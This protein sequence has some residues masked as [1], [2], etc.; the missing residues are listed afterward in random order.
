MPRPTAIDV[1]AEL[2][3]RY[4]RGMVR[5]SRGGIDEFS[6]AQVRAAVDL[7]LLRRV[8][9]G[10]LTFPGSDPFATVPTW[11]SDQEEDEAAALALAQAARAILPSLPPE[12]RWTPCGVTARR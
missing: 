9:P 7:G 11:S 1:A 10:V 3:A 6:Y 5:V 12:A 4:G 8:R 2:G